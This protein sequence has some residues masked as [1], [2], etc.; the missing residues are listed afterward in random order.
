[1]ER[2]SELGISRLDRLMSL[3][4]CP[5][6]RNEARRLDSAAECEGYLNEALERDALIATKKMGGDDLG[7]AE[8][9]S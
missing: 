9:H 6:K 8:T 7:N 1:M 5:L 4:D 2:Q 3:D